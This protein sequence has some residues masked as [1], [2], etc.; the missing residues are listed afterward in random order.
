MA[1]HLGDDAGEHGAG[2]RRGHRM[3]RGQPA[4]QR[5]E[6][7]LTAKAHTQNQIEG[8]QFVFMARQLCQ[9]QHAAGDELGRAAKLLQE[10]QAKRKT[11][12]I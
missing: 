6:S 1:S 9:I 2:R 3:R 8:K 4:M 11:P 7:G 10:K 5:I 12:D